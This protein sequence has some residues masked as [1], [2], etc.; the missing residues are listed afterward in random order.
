MRI[1]AFLRQRT[2]ATIDDRIIAKNLDLARFWICD[3]ARAG[4]VIPILQVMWDI[5]LKGA[6]G[7]ILGWARKMRDEI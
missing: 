6:T 2:W 5:E 1:W 3:R 4:L 7:E